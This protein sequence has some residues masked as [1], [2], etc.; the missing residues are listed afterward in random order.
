MSQQRFTGR[1]FTV[2]LDNGTQVLFDQFN[3]NTDIGIGVAKTQ[4]QPDGWTKGE[5]S[6]DGDIQLS[7]EEM[8]KLIDAARKAGSWEAMPP[9]DVNC[10]ALVGGNA[11]NLEVFGVKINSPNFQFD[12]T[13]SDRTVHTVNFMVTDPEF[14]KID[15]VPLADNRF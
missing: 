5:L 12:S 9:F 13:N 14:V 11:K 3:L 1:D 4:G 2:T 7:T 15:G 8:Q 10:Y 6:A